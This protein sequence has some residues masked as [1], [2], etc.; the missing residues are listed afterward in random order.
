M[1]KPEVIVREYS[2]DGDGQSMVCLTNVDYSDSLT[3][4]RRVLHQS[5]R[6]TAPLRVAVAVAAAVCASA[7]SNESSDSSVSFH[8]TASIQDLMLSV[9]DP[10]A[11]AIWESVATI[12]THEGTEERRPRTDEDWE[13]LRH[14][15]VRLVEASNLMLMGG[16]DVAR[17]GFRSEHPGIELEPEEVQ[18]LIEEDFETWTRLVN[19]YHSVAVSMF[20]AVQNRDADRLFDE[21]GP[22]DVTCERCHQRY[23][24]PGAT[25]A[26][27]PSTVGP[28]TPVPPVA[29]PAA[30]PTDVPTAG[31]D[32]ST[33]PPLAPMGGT[34]TIEGHVHLSGELPGNPIIRMGVDPL[35]AQL[36][37]GKQIVQESVLTSPDGSLANVFVRLQGTFPETPV[38]DEPV[39]IDQQDCVFIPR[40]VGARAGQNVQIK[41]SDPLLHNLNTQ[42]TTTNRFNV[43]Q[44][45]QGMV[46]EFQPVEEDG[47]LRI[48]C[49]LHRWMTEY[50][51]VVAHPYF[52]TTDLTGTFTLTDVPA[53]IHTIQAWHEEYGILTQTVTVE[54]DGVATADFTYP[55]AP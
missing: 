47:M 36:T 19:D 2:V 43:G 52:A 25:G 29:A 53:G 16:R 46:Y 35:C 37:E 48:R 45:V 23:W 27:M 6:P 11:D 34:G 32:T 39:V 33:A 26:P 51:G 50:I 38:P 13:A 15:A 54:A 55:E 30:A 4:V 5:R 21:G 28:D 7:C 31:A 17:P 14:E 1:T 44:P 22:L 49:D 42:T 41:N 20:E 10:A 9:V 8:P 18:E 40:V 3:P 12:V 24:Y